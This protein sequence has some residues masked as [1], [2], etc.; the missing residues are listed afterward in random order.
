VNQMNKL[1]TKE[2]IEIL[3]SEKKK[4][5]HKLAK[6]YDSYCLFPNEHDQEDWD[7]YSALVAALEMAVEALEKQ[8]PK[9]PKSIK[10]D[11]NEYM[12]L[13][14]PTCGHDV[15][16]YDAETGYSYMDNE[17]NPRMCAKCGQSLFAKLEGE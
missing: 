11:Y 10:E 16:M 14:C 7:N 8:I 2:A 1:E 5:E 3:L 12:D 4:A 6:A 13:Y 9:K 17:S 15:G